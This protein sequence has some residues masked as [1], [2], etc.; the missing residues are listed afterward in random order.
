MTT[1]TTLPPLT[2][3]ELPAEMLSE[4]LDGNGQR[5]LLWGSAST[6]ARLRL[7]CRAL[8]ALL[9]A[10]RYPNLCALPTGQIM[11][12]V[13]PAYAKN[14]AGCLGSDRAKAVL[15]EAECGLSVPWTQWPRAL[16]DAMLQGV[17]DPQWQRLKFITAPA[18]Q[19]PTKFSAKYSTVSKLPRAFFLALG[20]VQARDAARLAQLAVT[21]APDSRWGMMLEHSLF[22]LLAL[23][24]AIKRDDPWYL[25]MH[26]TDPMHLPD[27]GQLEQWHGVLR[28]HLL[29]AH[30]G[31]RPLPERCLAAVVD[32][33]PTPRET[34]TL[35]L[36]TERAEQACEARETARAAA[37]AAAQQRYEPRFFRRTLSD[38]VVAWFADRLETERRAQRRAA[39]Q[40]RR[41]RR[42]EERD[43]TRP[44][45]DAGAPPRP[46]V[47]VLDA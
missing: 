2:L 37:A 1:T 36:R 20:A 32:L 28:Q 7:T 16:A 31:T 44:R 19:Q 38:D 22:V 23:V 15:N 41:K 29:K 42:R 17:R 11:Y 43:V 45:S 14:P 47:I 24:Q 35:W 9:A 40:A 25:R 27:L 3:L 8:Y 13:P 6:L 10:P 5:S 26:L 39:D 33:L 46:G 21:L 18:W 12:R 4:I 30:A 34:L